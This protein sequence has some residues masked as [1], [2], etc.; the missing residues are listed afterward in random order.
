[1]SLYFAYNASNFKNRLV[2]GLS[3]LRQ[4]K[5]GKSTCCLITGLGCFGMAVGLVHLGVGV[6]ASSRLDLYVFIISFC[7][8][9][10]EEACY[11]PY[12]LGM[13]A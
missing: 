4:N 12:F 10:K 8:Y 9:Q 3:I 1:M 5:N 13:R 11:G 6:V 7:F 2:C